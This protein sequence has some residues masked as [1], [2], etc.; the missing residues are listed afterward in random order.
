M[1]LAKIEADL[2][3]TNIYD[4]FL[5]LYKTELIYDQRNFF[6]LAESD[7]QN[8]SEV[9]ELVKVN[10]YKN[11]CFTIGL[12]KCIDIVFVE[13]IAEVSGGKCDFVQKGDSISSKE[14]EMMAIKLS[15]RI[16]LFVVTESYGRKD[17]SKYCT[18]NI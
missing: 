3:G 1:K 2:R 17:S 14:D 16:I 18:N 5:D 6:I 8:P 9:I 15:K 7:V 12:G 11:R 13:A 10:S 4:P